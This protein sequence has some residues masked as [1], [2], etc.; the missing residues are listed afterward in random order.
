MANKDKAAPGSD[1]AQDAA[2]DQVEKEMPLELQ[3]FCI[4]LSTSDKRVEMIGA[5]FKV[6]G[7]AGRVKDVESA[8]KTRYDEFCNQP[9]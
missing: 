7:A 8:F 5:F 1:Q 2:G 3:E 4:R 6:E 9:A